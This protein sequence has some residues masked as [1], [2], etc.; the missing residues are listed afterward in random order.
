M[1]NAILS[2]FAILMSHSLADARTINVTGRGSSSSYCNAN[3]GNFCFNDVKRRSES[4]AERDVRWNCEMTQRGR[5]L[6]YTL[7]TSTFC[8]PSYLPPH[9]D[10]TWV[11]C[12]SDSRMQC[13]VQD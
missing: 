12:R 4:E 10:G 9:H 8:S 7:F 5:S 6:T 2:V 13:E 11:N 1:K 3:S